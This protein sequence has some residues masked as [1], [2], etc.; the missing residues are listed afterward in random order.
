MN[1]D[2][3]NYL[4]NIVEAI[5]LKNIVVLPLKKLFFKIKS[6]V[7]MRLEKNNL[8]LIYLLLKLLLSIVRLKKKS[9]SQ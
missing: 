1:K 4:F 7:Y 9:N 2:F 6:G 3:Y 8:I 5:Y